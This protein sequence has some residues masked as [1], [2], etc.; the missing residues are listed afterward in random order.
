MSNHYQRL[1]RFRQIAADLEKLIDDGI[2]RPG[3][4][5]PREAELSEKYGVTRPTV[6]KA[7]GVLIAAEKVISLGRPMGYYVHGVKERRWILSED[8]RFVDPWTSMALTAPGKPRQE[9][10]VELVTADFVVQDTPLREWFEL[11]KGDPDEFVMRNA[12]RTLDNEPVQLAAS[13]IPLGLAENTPLRRP[14]PMDR[15]AVRFLV[16]T[17]GEE[18][19]GCSDCIR[20]RPANGRETRLLELPETASVTEVVRQMRFGDRHVLLVERLVVEARGATM[21]SGVRA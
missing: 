10:T 7:Y 15:D 14:A 17:C 19:V 6:S 16:A 1:P 3:D 11:R 21:V 18:L 9:V 5:M 20:E 2:L 4:R 12:L 8:G 13:F